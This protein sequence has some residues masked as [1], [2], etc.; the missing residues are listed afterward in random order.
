MRCNGRLP[1]SDRTRPAAP[2][3]AGRARKSTSSSPWRSYEGLKSKGE[4]VFL[5]SLLLAALHLRRGRWIRRATSDKGA[6]A[7]CWRARLPRDLEGAESSYSSARSPALTQAAFRCW[8][9]LAGVSSRTSA[10]TLFPPS[11]GKS[12]SMGSPSITF[13]FWP[14][15]VA[16]VVDVDEGECLLPFAVH[17]GGWRR[18]RREGEREL[19]RRT[20]N[21]FDEKCRWRRLSACSLA[22][23]LALPFSESGFEVVYLP[24]PR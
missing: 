24:S 3:P 20:K 8:L 18:G 10:T 19:A 7:L 13:Q 23:S 12:F 14:A 4:S 16:A 5:R 15:A 6:R 9:A 21:P 22:H 1:V 11:K 2:C 17:A